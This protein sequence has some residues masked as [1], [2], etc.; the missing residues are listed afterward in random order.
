MTATDTSTTSAIDTEAYQPRDQYF[1]KPYID[2]DED[3]EKPWPHRNVHG[4]FEGTDT[5]FTFY[6]PAQEEWAGRM[7]HPLEGAHAGHEEAFAGMMGQLMGGLPMIARLGG[8]MVESNCGHIGDDLDPRA[9]AD[10]TLYGHR[11]GIEAARF[12]KHVA[13]QVYGREPDYS[14]V[15]GGSGGGR[16][17]PLHL[18]Y[19]DG[20]Y[21]GAL[22]FMGGGNVEPHGTKSRVRSEQPVHFGSMFNVQR[23]LDGGKLDAVID[24]MQPGGTG[25]PFEGLT[26]H[27]RGEL[28]ALY[29]LGYPRG[30]EFMISK[31]MGQIW[32]WSSIAEML[33]EEDADYFTS[34]WTKPGYVGFDELQYL[35]KDLIDLDRPV[36]RTV[37]ARD[38]SGAEFAGPE[39]ADTRAR[40]IFSASNTGNW[41]LPI[42][43]HV[44]G[45][46]EGYR[47]GAGVRILTGAAAG[48]QLYCTQFI[49]DLLFCDGRAE[50][51][52]ERFRGVAAGDMV[53]VDNRAF[54]A[55][56]YY[57]RYHISDD[58]LNN[59]LRLDGE[60]IYPQHDVPL[61][62]PLM[63]VPYSGQYEGKLLWI[64]HTHDASLWPPQGII[65]KRA[66]EAAQGPEQARD[67]FRLQWTENAEHVTPLLLPSNPVR[68]TSTWLIDYMPSIEQ[69]L[70]D[71]ANWVE[72]GVPPPETNYTFADGKVSLPSTAAA[73]GGTQPVLEVAADGKTRLQVRVGQPFALRVAAEAP[74]GAG[75]ITQIDWDLDGSGRFAT[76]QRIPA[77]ETQVIASLSHSYD[78]GGTYFP[79]ARVRLNREGDPTAARQ[80]ENLAAARVIVVEEINGEG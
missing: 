55:F 78:T 28:A 6:F 35:E 73:R 41:D 17:S 64:H 12:S 32:L 47:L 57:Y 39:Y 9:G 29:R 8:Y 75:A 52:L 4:G 53:H 54:L 1:G 10:P 66:V 14:Y 21:D 40:A 3:R 5:R 44:P 18:E 62:S 67:R 79:V 22:P 20:V 80:V 46:G 37:S 65:Y 11:A 60:P 43:V 7:Y 33:I 69:G 31:P 42:A 61:A 27:E 56:C 59:F 16:R 58:P 15:W 72:K 68:A 38:L 63:G 13:K 76:T 45:L 30:D 19:C 23:L 74:P 51:N 26:T 50:A 36:A 77:G 2:R 25:N 24:A 34:F 48:R 71:L 49:G 70:A